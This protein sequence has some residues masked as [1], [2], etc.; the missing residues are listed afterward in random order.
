MILAFQIVKIGPIVGLGREKTRR[1][2][3]KER[4]TETKGKRGDRII[5]RERQREK[6]RVIE[7]EM[8]RKSE[9]D[10]IGRAHV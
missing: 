1:R 3:G 2:G 6:Q 8:E 7:R 10:E 4:E 5:K 9:R